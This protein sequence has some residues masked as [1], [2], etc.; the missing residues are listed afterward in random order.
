MNRE[1]HT[2]ETYGFLWGKSAAAACPDR[3]HFNDMQEVV[4]E[5]LVRGSRGIEI[6][7]GCGY[8]SSIMARGN[9]SVD[10]VSTELSDGVYRSR[11]LTSG[12]G[13]VKLI[14]CSVLDIPLKDSI[15]DFAY[16]F[17]VLHHTTNPK[18]GLLAIAR[19]L[20]KDCPVFLYL[21][22]DHSE[23]RLKYIA[24]KVVTALRK[25][26][27]KIPRKALYCLSVVFSPFVFVIFSLPSK[28]L[29]R[30]KAT[31]D[32]S[33]K[34]PFNFGTGPF[35]LCG[36]IYDRFGAPIEYRFSRKQILDLMT[37]CRFRKISITRLVNVAGWVVWGYKK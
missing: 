12:L 34:I 32:F 33:R 16:S 13:N 37:E 21:Y 31:R 11:E 27:V 18:K 2:K 15:F 29:G 30:F 20:K 1:R 8:D 25:I 35:S 5:P 10:I 14:Q 9:P 7:S 3:W 4:G 28:I 23:N 19:V 22:E 17:G 24:V 26:T 6:G 36:D